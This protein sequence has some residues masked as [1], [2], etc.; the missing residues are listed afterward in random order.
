MMIH[1]EDML[2]LPLKDLLPIMQE[3]VKRSTYFG[4]PTMK[5]PTDAWVYQ[6]IIA[7]LKPD[8]IIE[9]GTWHGGSALMLS[10]LCDQ[11]GTGRV[12]SIDKNPPPKFMRPR[13]I[14]IENDACEVGLSGLI[15]KGEKVLVI[16]D[17]SHDYDQCLSVLRKYSE[18][19]S[20][21]SYLIV[22]DTICYH[23]LEE[24]PRPGPYEAVETF[25]RENKN[26][27][28]DRNREPYLVTW[29]PKGY[30]KRVR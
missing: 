10:H 30:L 22:E 24:G 14:W 29:N 9:I 13:I 6:E 3:K 21:G 4:I 17:S 8:V 27:E 28:A 12:I 16:E 15:L 7:E 2:P 23:G 1:Q 20:V 19:V 26:F 5:S 25:L 18:V 11:L